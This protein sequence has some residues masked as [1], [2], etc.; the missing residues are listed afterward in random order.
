MGDS[1]E[2]KT[3]RFDT[4]LF[5]SPQPSDRSVTELILV[6]AVKR[7]VENSFERNRRSS[8]EIEKPRK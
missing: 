5:D 1:S 6:V 8:D 3:V 7:H 4:I 2:N